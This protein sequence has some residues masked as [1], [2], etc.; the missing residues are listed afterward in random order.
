MTEWDYIWGL[1]L[2][3]VFSYV[4]PRL[5]TTAYFRSK[6]EHHRKVIETLQEGDKHNGL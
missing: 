4:V 2:L 1:V 5:A 3:L 6:L